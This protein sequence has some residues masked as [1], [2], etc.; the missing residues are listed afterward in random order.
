MKTQFGKLA[1]AAGFVLAF[2]FTLSCPSNKDD[3]NPSNI[4]GA[5]ISSSSVN[6]NSSSSSGGSSS[7]EI[8]SSSSSYTP[9]SSSLP[10]SSSQVIVP[11]YGESITDRDGQTYQTVVIG[12]R[13]WM[14]RNLNYE[15]IG[16][17]CGDGSSLSNENTANCYAYGRLY[18][19]S[20]ANS[21]CP[22]GWRLPSNAEWTALIDFVGGSSIAGTKLKAKSGWYDINTGGSG[23]GTDDYGFAALPGGFGYYSNSLNNYLFGSFNGYWWSSTRGADGGYMW[24]MYGSTTDVRS[25]TFGNQ[26]LYSVRCVKN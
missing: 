11:V 13:T 24:G 19:W 6:N 20:T 12:G 5:L 9:S 21:V 17:K 8:G 14:A 7:S 22:T 25:T 3:D 15:T 26:Y 10:S 2:V 16:S 4:S 1:V 18:E 23:N